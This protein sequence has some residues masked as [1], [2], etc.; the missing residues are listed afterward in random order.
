MGELKKYT[1]N[2]LVAALF[3]VKIVFF[4]ISFTF[5]FLR[6]LVARN[7]GRNGYTDYSI[8]RFFTQRCVHDDTIDIFSNMNSI[9]LSTI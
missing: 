4:F 7:P 1:N 9:C 5:I 8:S 3:S 2:T 6:A